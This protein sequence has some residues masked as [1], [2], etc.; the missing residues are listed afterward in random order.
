ML[1]PCLTHSF[2]H[3]LLLILLYPPSFLNCFPTHLLLTSPYI[4][5]TYLHIHNAIIHSLPTHCHILTHSSLF[6]FLPQ[7]STY[8]PFTYLSLFLSH[9]S[10]DLSCY[11]PILTLF[12]STLTNLLTPNLYSLI[13]VKP[14][15]T[16]GDVNEST[17]QCHQ[18][19]FTFQL[20]AILHII[21]NP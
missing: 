10:P 19:P 16:R 9:L 1:L 14:T 3:I 13:N 5:A 15:R 18:L 20:L 4:L 12:F 7:S 17:H 6:I 21:L 11:L 8:P 2:I